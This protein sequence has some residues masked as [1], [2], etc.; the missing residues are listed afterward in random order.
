MR[1]QSCRIV[2]EPEVGA[3]LMVGDV[4]GVDL[5]ISPVEGLVPNKKRKITN[6]GG[7]Q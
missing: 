6:K 5:S 3:S 2:L 1:T 7:R 4:L